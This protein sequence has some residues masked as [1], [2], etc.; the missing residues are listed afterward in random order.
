MTLHLACA[1]AHESEAIATMV[2]ELLH[3]IVARVHDKSFEFEYAETVGRAS[4]WM[5]EE[6]YTVMLAQ[7]DAKPVGFLALY[8]SYAL[9]TAGVY[10]TIPEFYVRP[11]YRS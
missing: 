5:K 4:T 3:E 11:T 7:M 1:E 10:G 8:E 2:G 9:Y 6:R